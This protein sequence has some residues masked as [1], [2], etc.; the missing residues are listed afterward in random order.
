M[1]STKELYRGFRTT[2]AS[3]MKEAGFKSLPGGHLGWMRQVGEEH[4]F[5]WFQANKWGWHPVWGSTFTLEF[6]MAPNADDFMTVRG[7]REHIGE[8]LES[9]PELDELRQLNNRVIEQLP[10]TVSNLAV[11]GKLENGMEYVLEGYLVDPEPAV[12]ARDL[13]LNYYSPDDISLWALYFKTKL[14]V[15]ISIFVEE[16]KTPERLA[17]ERFNQ[18]LGHVQNVGEFAQKVTLLR[19]YL[20]TETDPYYRSIAERWLTQF[21]KD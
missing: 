3:Q 17:H 6:Q 11:K 12:Y 9:F 20:Q 14:P 19:S 13:W 16:K 4:L 10:G 5:L 15:F 18:V 8:L 1:V 2:L 7:R 21:A